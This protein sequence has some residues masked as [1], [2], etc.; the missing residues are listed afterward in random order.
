MCSAGTNNELGQ[1]SSSSGMCLSAGT[2]N[3]LR[4]L[5]FSSGMCSESSTRSSKM[6][7]S[8]QRTNTSTS[9]ST[10]SIS[11]STSSL[12][13]SILHRLKRQMSALGNRHFAAPEILNKIQHV[14]SNSNTNSNS[15][16]IIETLSEY[17][18]KYGLLVDAYSTVWDIP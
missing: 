4:E 3:S 9:T 5:S 18:A 12:S 16:D 14:H 13:R 17:M 8:Q 7:R 15:H 2:N 10:S 1:L 6:R 11:R